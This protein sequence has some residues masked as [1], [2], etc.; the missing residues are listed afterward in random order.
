MV[1]PSSTFHNDISFFFLSVILN[2][3]FWNA[4]NLFQNQLSPNPSLTLAKKRFGHLPKLFSKHP[5]LNFLFFFIIRPDRL[6]PTLNLYP[7]LLSVHPAA[8]SFFLL[9][10]KHSL[11]YRFSSIFLSI[12]SVSIICFHRFVLPFFSLSFFSCQFLLFINLSINPSLSFSF[13]LCLS[14][15]QFPEF[16]IFPHFY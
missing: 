16:C 15:I 8:G 4:R 10:C 12:F 11:L 13:S 9:L 3:I 1:L 2:S 5:S 14:F 6:Q 7:S